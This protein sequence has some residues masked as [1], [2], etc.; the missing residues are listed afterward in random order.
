M[1]SQSIEPPNTTSAFEKLSVHAGMFMHLPTHRYGTLYPKQADGVYRFLYFDND[2][3]ILILFY[4]Y[5][6]INF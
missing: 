2:I 1:P 3:N 4:V 5:I 6:L